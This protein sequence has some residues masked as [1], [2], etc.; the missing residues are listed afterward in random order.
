VVWIGLISY[1][2]YLFHWP[3]L[4]FVHI[5]KGDLQR[6]HAPKPVY[7]ADA[8]LISLILSV[9]T[10]YFIEKRIRHHKSRWT[11]PMLV[12]AFIL[13]GAIATSIDNDII[14]PRYNPPDVSKLS[15]AAHDADMLG[16]W[17]TL[18]KD[19]PFYIQKTG[20]SGKQVLFLGDSNM[21]QYA[22]RILTELINNAPSQRGALFITESGIPPIP[23][24]YSSEGKSS[25][26]LLKEIR[27]YILSDPRIDR[28]VI[29]ARWCNYF[30]KPSRWKT[31]GVVLDTPEGEEQA[32][33]QLAFLIHQLSLQ[34]RRVYLVLNIP[35]GLE[36]DP[37]GFYPRNFIGKIDPKKKILTKE[38]FL[39]ENGAVLDEIAS[40]ARRAGAEV[41]DPMDYL[42][43]NGICIAEDEKGVPIRFDEG[44]LRPGYVR[45]HVKYLDRTIVP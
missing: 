20:G 13:V 43:T 28:I 34:G 14:P 1:P 24:T 30:S 33:S 11:I 18:K 41:I 17:T 2:L 9:T 6:G 3:A 42:C 38:N 26:R 4:S 25:D 27:E 36:L 7:I 19:I 31:D 10:Y 16:G 23:N 5:V 37:K 45:E 8:L 22:P 21:Q 15:Q 32:L 40:I 35:T 44:H 29:S 39:K 12:A